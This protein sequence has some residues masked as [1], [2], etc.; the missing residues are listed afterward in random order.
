MALCS[1]QRAPSTALHLAG[2]TGP[3]PESGPVGGH[4]ASSENP[5]PVSAFQKPLP[6]KDRLH[7]A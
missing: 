4:R 1:A 2:L 5:R 6:G 7:S 3:S